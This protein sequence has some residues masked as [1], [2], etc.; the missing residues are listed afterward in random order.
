MTQVTVYDD[1]SLFDGSDE[2]EEGEEGLEGVVVTSVVSVSD[3]ANAGGE[4]V[5]IT[6]NGIHVSLSLSLSPQ[7][8]TSDLNV[9]LPRPLQVVTG[10]SV[11]CVRW[12][13]GLNCGQGGWETAGCTL[14][15]STEG[16]Y[17][18]HCQDQ[19]SFSIL[20]VS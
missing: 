18:C 9:S 20:E 2:C 12:N 5:T 16:V 7:S 3:S 10:D 19:G 14:E 1:T 15:Y 11:Q 6:F 4:N 17:R 13:S 8:L